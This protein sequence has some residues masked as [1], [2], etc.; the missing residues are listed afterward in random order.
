MLNSIHDGKTKV[1]VFAVIES[2]GKVF[3]TTRPHDERMPF[4]LPGGKV[5]QGETLI[6]ALKREVFE[7]GIDIDVSN[8]KLV[9][10]EVIRDNNI[11]WF[12]LDAEPT[13]LKEYKEKYRGI[14]VE[15]KTIDEVANSG[16]GNSFVKD[17]FK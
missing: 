8:A 17:L 15:S 2:N 14:M 11:F 13:L 12:L 1:S 10:N 7:E 9:H 4:G 6:E 3:V 16:N 5:D